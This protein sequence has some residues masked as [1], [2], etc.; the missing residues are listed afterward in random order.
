[1][2]QSALLHFIQRVAEHRGSILQLNTGSITIVAEWIP[3]EREE[4]EIFR[5][6]MSFQV[7]QKA[8]E[9]SALSVFNLP[10]HLC[11]LNVLHAW[12]AEMQTWMRSAKRVN[13]LHIKLCVVFG[14]YELPIGF[15]SQ[16]DPIDW[17]SAPGQIF[18]FGD[19]VFRRVIEH[20]YRQHH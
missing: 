8:A 2:S 5:S 3:F 20:R 15:F 14:L 19:G 12:P 13:K 4:G 6:S 11:L 7:L 10:G 16:F 17:I 9:P 18:D 1:M